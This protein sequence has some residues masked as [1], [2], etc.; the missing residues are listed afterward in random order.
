MVGEA[1]LGGQGLCVLGPG[2]ERGEVSCPVGWYVGAAVQNLIHRVP[3]LCD[4][5]PR[6]Y[7]VTVISVEDSFW[8]KQNDNPLEGYACCR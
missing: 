7:T 8:G 3:H 6:F 2:F 5:V 4:F 1:G